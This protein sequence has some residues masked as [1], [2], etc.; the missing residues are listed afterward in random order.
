DAAGNVGS[1]GQRIVFVEQPFGRPT[2]NLGEGDDIVNLAERG[3]G[4]M[5]G[6]TVQAGASGMEVNWGGFSGAAMVSGAIWSLALPASQVPADGGTTLTATVTGP[7]GG[8]DAS[9]Q[10]VVD[11][12]AP[13][14]PA[15]NPVTGDDA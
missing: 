6:G 14:A 2:I 7:G 8:A 4:V 10:V 5:L 13:A 9:R 1:P 12:I 3:D 11:T 15:V